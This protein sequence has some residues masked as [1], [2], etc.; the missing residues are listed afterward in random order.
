VGY[1]RWVEP[2]NQCTLPYTTLWST[3]RALALNISLFGCKLPSFEGM[4]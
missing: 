3:P 2:P 1:L 4:V